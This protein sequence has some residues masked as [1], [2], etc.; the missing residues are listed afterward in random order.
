MKSLIEKV[1]A[2]YQ[3]LKK[4]LSFLANIRG[5]KAAVRYFAV[6]LPVV[7][8]LLILSLVF[9]NDMFSGLATGAFKSIVGLFIVWTF[10]RFAI[11]EID[12]MALF[13][14]DPKAYA[15]FFGF[16]ILLVTVCIATS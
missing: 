5:F 3:R 2:I 10:D 16:I 13:K 4:T 11:P 6:M 8:A 15:I 14:T 1:I 9:Y 12:T 7:S